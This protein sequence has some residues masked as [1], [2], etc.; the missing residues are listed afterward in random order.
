LALETPR[1]RVWVWWLCVSFALAL[2]FTQLD[3]GATRGLPSVVAFVVWFA[4]AAVGLGCAI[5]VTR[6]LAAAGDG[7]WQWTPVRLALGGV[8]GSALFAPLSLGLEALLPPAALDPDDGW[9]DAWEARGGLY[10]LLAE[11]LRLLPPYL[12]SWAILNVVPLIAVARP[13]LNERNRESPSHAPTAR[14]EAPVLVATP[15]PT[16]SADSPAQA[17]TAI[18][19]RLPPAIGDDVV[20]VQSDLHYL[21]IRTPRGRATVLGTLAEFEAQWVGLG[22]RVHRSF[23]VAT[24]HVKSVKRSGAGWFCTLSDGSRV[25][26]SRRRVAAVKETFGVGFV[27]DQPEP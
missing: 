25:P 21:L 2:L 12:A 19:Q 3:A 5:L 26:V 20:S 24:R 11:W 22:V 4:H 23:W 27:Q 13:M 8:I 7:W 1:I 17:E 16:I 10:T 6:Q 15:E 14:V 18:R 9:L